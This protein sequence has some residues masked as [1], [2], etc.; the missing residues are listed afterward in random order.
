MPQS[1]RQIRLN[2]KRLFR[3]CYVKDSF[4]ERRARKAIR[5]VLTRRRRGYM[6]LL[7]QFA[8]L[9]RLERFR[10]LA[11]IQTAKTLSPGLRARIHSQLQSVY[12]EDLRADFEPKAELVGGIRIQIDSDVYDNSVQGK[13]A[14]LQRTFGILP[15]K[16]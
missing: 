11:H 10:H 1:A 5:L 4:D 2:A 16:R 9:V 13:L 7:S 3:W 8:R 6:V 15:D 14:A 12:G